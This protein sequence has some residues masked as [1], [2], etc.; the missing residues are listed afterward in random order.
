VIR[1]LRACCA[2]GLLSAACATT[3]IAVKPF[4]DVARKSPCTETKNRLFLIDGTSVLW[5]RAGNCPD[6][7]YEQTWYGATPGEVLCRAQDSIAGP[8]KT[9][10]PSRAAEFDTMIENLDAPDLGLGGGHKV[11]RIPL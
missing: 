4:Q 8:R 3:A 9:C 5:D 2:A 11:R 1:G 6:N 10:D 7:A